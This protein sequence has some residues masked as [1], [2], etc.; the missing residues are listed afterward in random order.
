[1]ECALGDGAFAEEAD[2]HP[3]ASGHLVGERQAHGQ[4]QPAR[5]DGVAA[6]EAGAGVE[7]MHGAAAAAAAA[8]HMAVHFGQDGSCGH[9]AQQR[10]AVFPVR[11]HH[12]VVR[13]QG[14]HHTCGHRFLADINVQESADLGGAVELHALLL[15]PPH[16]QHL[17]EQVAGMVGVRVSRAAR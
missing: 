4:R 2:G 8:L 9:A 12:G 17:A 15:E 14:A 11:C 10:V 1:M 3:G 13:S 7:E 5:H 6:E 16:P